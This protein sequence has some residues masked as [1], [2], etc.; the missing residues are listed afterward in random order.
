MP[1]TRGRVP[2]LGKGMGPDLGEYFDWI[3][4][5]VSFYIL[6]GMNEFVCSGRDITLYIHV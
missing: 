1:D 3:S 2:D 4:Y 5:E 6:I